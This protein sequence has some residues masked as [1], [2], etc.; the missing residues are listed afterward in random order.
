MLNWLFFFAIIFLL[1]FNETAKVSLHF[2]LASYCFLVL[3]KPFIKPLLHCFSRTLWPIFDD[4]HRYLF[5]FVYYFCTLS[6]LVFFFAVIRKF[7]FHY[8]VL[9]IFFF[10]HK[11][12]MFC[13]ATSW[14][15]S[16]CFSNLLFFKIFFFSFYF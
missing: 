9:C 5:D 15:F 14:K 16:F 8:L 6:W 7:F 13:F 10:V 4:F 11:L 1:F 3:L 12:K 2:A